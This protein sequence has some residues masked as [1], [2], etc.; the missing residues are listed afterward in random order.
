[1][2]RSRAATEPIG[3]RGEQ[4]LRTV[5]RQI[6]QDDI[7][8]FAA[9]SGD[10]HPQHVD[11]TW[12]T[13]SMFGQ[14]IAHGMLV[15]A[16]ATGLVPLEPERVVALRHVKATFKRPVLPG[17]AICV[18]VRPTSARRLDDRHRL[19]TS[20][21]RILNQAEQLVALVVVEVLFR[22]TPDGS[23]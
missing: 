8:A 20:Q 2:I 3:T 23:A 13:S 17:D 11:A 10:H 22:D 19:I 4:G 12:A 6:T 14:R 16:C 1:M 15:L 7:D 5:A 18:D 9:V 21:W